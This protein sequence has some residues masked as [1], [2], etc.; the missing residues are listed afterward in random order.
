MPEWEFK[1]D[2]LLQNIEDSFEISIL[3]K[4]GGDS[5]TYEIFKT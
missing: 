1:L 3:R 5:V 4:K 2:F